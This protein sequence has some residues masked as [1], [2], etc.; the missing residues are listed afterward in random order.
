[1]N[2][3]RTIEE[4]V[5]TIISDELK[6]S[7]EEIGR[8][9]KLDVDLGADSL[10]VRSIAMELEEEFSIEEIPEKD[11]EKFKTVG[12]IITYIEKIVGE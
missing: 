6:I 5:I 1:M 7:E 9:S 8:Q 12:D 11:E 2:Q 4:R 10:D 3:Q